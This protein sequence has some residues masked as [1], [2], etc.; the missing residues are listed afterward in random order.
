MDNDGNTVA[1][2]VERGLDVTLL[3]DLKQRP[4]DRIAISSNQNIGSSSSLK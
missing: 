2:D 3:P 4:T 1:G